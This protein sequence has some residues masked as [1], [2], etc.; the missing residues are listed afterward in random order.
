MGFLASYQD[1]LF[2]SYVSVDDRDGWVTSLKNLLE[3]RL[4]RLL[5]DS[6]K[7]SIWAEGLDVGE[8]LSSD[9]ITRLDQTALFL[10]VLSPG[11]LHS[12]WCDAGLAE[13]AE[14]GAFL[15][16]LDSRYERDILTL[17]AQKARVDEQ[18]PPQID[19]SRYHARFWVYDRRI[20]A[21]RTYGASDGE[22][23]E[24]INDLAFKLEAELRRLERQSD[25]TPK[26]SEQPCEKDASAQPPKS[27][28]TAAT[29][30]VADVTDD[31]I[32]ELKKL[33]RRFEQAGLRIVPDSWH[34]QKDE[35]FGE[36]VEGNLAKAK[37]FVQLLSG[38]VGRSVVGIAESRVGFQYRRAQEMGVPTLQWRSPDPTLA[39]LEKVVDDAE[40]LKLL[41]GNVHADPLETFLQYVVDQATQKPEAKS[42]AR[43]RQGWVCINSRHTEAEGPVTKELCRYLKS[44][45]LEYIFPKRKGRPEE[46]RK[47]LEA[48][49]AESDGMIF[50][51]DT[52]ENDWVRSQL[53]EV[54]KIMAKNR[55]HIAQP[56]AVYE[57]PPIPKEPLEIN[58]G[59]LMTVA[60]HTGLDEQQLSPFLDLVEAHAR[61][62]LEELEPATL[63]D[64]RDEYDVFLAHNSA[65]KEQIRAIQRELQRHQVAAWLDEQQIAP[66]QWYQDVIQKSVKKVK[67]T[68]VFFGTKGLGRWQSLELKAFITRCVDEG[69]PLIPVLLPGVTELPP[70]LVFLKELHWVQFKS[71]DDAAAIEG[72]RWGIT[73]RKP[74]F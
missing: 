49:V 69:F 72:L 58:L 52:A 26:Q 15:K 63:N 20:G 16:L 46:I 62:V 64:D 65:D 59:G 73:G 7:L 66:G 37:L 38:V 2:I 6:T 74:V 67:S 11:Y 14:L 71:L 34:T 55:Q 18:A 57:G 30:F 53:I 3:G 44:C 56:K 25:D 19:G 42:Q 31:L 70:D 47:D 8:T 43:P 24:T 54:R 22:F 1:D 50:V 40:H 10:V 12:P 60:C 17:V 27:D 23:V 4:R 36:L 41:Q 29:V 21:L 45:N 32:P 13:R 51:H 61:S 39:E 28:A 5:G 48:R 9:T 68:A 35:G 33:R